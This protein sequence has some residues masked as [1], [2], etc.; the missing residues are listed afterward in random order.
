MYS[1]RVLARGSRGTVRL[2]GKRHYSEERAWTVQE[3]VVSAVQREHV[4][5]MPTHNN[6]IDD[7]VAGIPKMLRTIKLRQ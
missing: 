6:Y 4:A 1:W 5:K 2:R 3:I 7:K